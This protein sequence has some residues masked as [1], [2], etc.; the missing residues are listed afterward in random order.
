MKMNLLAFP[1]LVLLALL[2]VAAPFVAKHRTQAGLAEMENTLA[3]QAREITRLSGTKPTQPPPVAQSMPQLSNEELRELMRLRSEVGPL[4]HAAAETVKLRAAQSSAAVSSSARREEPA[5]PNYWPKDQL[6]NV[7]FGTPEAAT[8]TAFWILKNGDMKALLA[9]APP[10]VLAGVQKEMEKEGPDAFQDEFK[11]KTQEMT[12]RASG[13]RVLNKKSDESGLV[14]LR[15]SFEGEGVTEDV[16]LKQY[17]TDWKILEFG[18]PKLIT[19][20]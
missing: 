20:H 19:D 3:E 7:G 16:T 9:C 12:G 1:L 11:K 10:E 17:G 6:A 8:Q 15:V 13:Y 5:G 4:R 2:S 14:T 18:N